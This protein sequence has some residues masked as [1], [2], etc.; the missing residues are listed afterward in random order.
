[1]QAEGLGG[2]MCKRSHQTDALMQSSTALPSALPAAHL[3]GAH[4]G[5][6]RQQ[7]AEGEAHAPLE[8]RVLHTHLRALGGGALSKQRLCGCPA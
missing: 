7:R 1:M 4:D 3:D 2:E 5:D 8:H 6:A